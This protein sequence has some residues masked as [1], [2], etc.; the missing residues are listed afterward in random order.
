MHTRAS[1]PQLWRL[2]YE[3]EYAG[4]S[5]FTEECMR[6]K[7]R[8]DLDITIW[9]CHRFTVWISNHQGNKWEQAILVF[10][11]HFT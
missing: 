2:S 6:E 10:I 1:S 11:L 4:R 8:Y 5:P 7:G 9:L 3:G